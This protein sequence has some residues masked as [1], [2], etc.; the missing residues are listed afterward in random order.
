MVVSSRNALKRSRKTK[1]VGVPS[2]D[3]S[4]I[5]EDR[6]SLRDLIIEASQELGI[7]K[8]VN[9]GVSH[10]VISDL[11]K[12]ALDFFGSCSL[13]KHNQVGVQPSPFGYGCKNIGSNGD[14]GDLEYL[15]LH[16]TDSS[17]H[18]PSLRKAVADYVGAVKGLAS[19]LLELM[20]EGLWVSDKS[21]LSN[22]I[23][24][25]QSDS[26]LR[27]NHY[28]PLKH[29][30]APLSPERIGFGEHSDPQILTILRSNDVAGLQVCMPDGLW[31][32]VQPDPSAFYVMVGDALQV[33]TNGRF[34]SVKHRAMANSSAAQ[35][36][37]STIFFG[38]PPLNA[39]ISPLN[40]MVSSLTPNLYLPF[41]WGEYKRAM[42]TSR[43]T[44]ALLSCRHQEEKLLTM[45]E[46]TLDMENHI[47]SIRF[48]KADC[49]DI[50]FYMQV[51][52]DVYGSCFLSQELSNLAR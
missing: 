4:F 14:M 51:K 19:E 12:H 35:A 45:V 36:R 42:R 52:K 9:H 49:D 8:V 44:K 11:E 39:L 32:P 48:Y 31:V 47:H 10:L 37:L 15:L 33:L 40:E 6:S 3:M 50:P 1:G 2:I 23:K 28:P 29:L 20:G 43:L 13:D 34:T 22:M 7:F 27:L 16:A 21:I 46:H 25:V 5:K 17:T 30:P 24:D 41:T 18:P 38:A 26:L